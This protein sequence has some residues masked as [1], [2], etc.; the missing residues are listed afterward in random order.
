MGL[1]V[2][3][4]LTNTRIEIQSTDNDSNLIFIAQYFNST[5]KVSHTELAF[6]SCHLI[7]NAIFFFL[8]F[9]TR[10]SR[11]SKH[12]I[13][14]CSMWIGRRHQQTQKSLRAILSVRAGCH[15]VIIFRHVI[16]PVGVTANP[17]VAESYRG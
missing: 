13:S 15:A 2:V 11:E 17:L 12:Q 14:Q 9:R 3:D 1:I 16:L 4:N 7:S 6:D 5:D 8:I 10:V